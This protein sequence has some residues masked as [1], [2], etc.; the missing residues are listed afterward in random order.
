MIDYEFLRGQE[1]ETV[2]K[3][4]CVARAAAFEMFR[5]K[6]PNKMTNHGSTANGLNWSDG[7]IEYKEFHTVIN[8]TVEGF[9]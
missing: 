1:N 2:V 6:S 5:F 3:E 8:E 7:H 9:S 4:L